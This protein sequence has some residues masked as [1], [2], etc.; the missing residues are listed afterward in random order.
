MR[1]PARALVAATLLLSLLATAGCAGAPAEPTAGPTPGGSPSTPSGTP[2]GEPGDPGSADPADPATWIAD[3]GG[4]G[5]I[6]SGER[7][8]D[9][10]PLL[11]AF[12]RVELPADC[13]LASFRGSG[14]LERLTV[15]MVTDPADLETIIQ[16]FVMT[17]G[18]PQ[19][20]P[21]VSPRTEAGVAL[22]ASEAQLLAA[23][24]DAVSV[25]DDA[26]YAVFELATGDGAFLYFLVSRPEVGTV[27]P[28][29]FVYGIVASAVPGVGADYCA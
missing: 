23:H 6:R 1:S 8:T 21:A 2:T 4:I 10:A 3:F 7:V 12:D 25:Q 17:A 5:P 20:P 15:S 16:V 26:G 13:N 24:P 28:S 14:V 27:G 29:A 19:S 11:G 9:V 22:G 18:D